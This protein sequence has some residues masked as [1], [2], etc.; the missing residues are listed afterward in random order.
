MAARYRV[1]VDWTDK[2]VTDSDEI[3]VWAD[4]EKE[5]ISK[6]RKQWRLTIGAQW[7]HCRLEKVWILTP[8][9]MREFA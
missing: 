2:D 3:Q 9:R 5:A 7:L 1:V 6:A 4:S 8:A